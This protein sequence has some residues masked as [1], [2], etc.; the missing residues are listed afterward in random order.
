[1][2]FCVDGISGSLSWIS[3]CQFS[4]MFLSSFLI[5]CSNLKF[6]GHSESEIGFLLA[7]ISCVKGGDI[8]LCFLLLGC[9]GFGELLRAVGTESSCCGLFVTTGCEAAFWA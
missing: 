2:D 5:C 4:L 7:D 9:S 8:C 6:M 3:G 1:M